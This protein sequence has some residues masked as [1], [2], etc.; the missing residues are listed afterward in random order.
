MKL[1]SKVAIIA[2]A[3]HGIGQGIAHCLAKEGADVAVVDLNGDNARKVADE[4]YTMRQITDELAKTLNR[5]V[6]YP[7]ILN[8]RCDLCPA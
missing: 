7:I 8:T 5:L 3:G 1:E 4:V 2:G 6:L